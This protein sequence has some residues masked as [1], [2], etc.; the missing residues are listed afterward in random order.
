MTVHVSSHR[1]RVAQLLLDVGAVHVNVER[2]FIF[3]SGWAS[4]V[5][6]DCRRL[7]SFPRERREV[8]ALATEV[9][10]GTV[11]RA[12]VDLVAG[13]ETAGIP[14]AAWIAERLDLPMV[15]VRKQP[16]GFGRLAQIEGVLG[17]GQ[18]VVLVEDLA[19]DG[20]S[21]VAFSRALREAGAVVEHAVVVFYYGIYPEAEATLRAAGLTLHALTD[22]ATTLQ[23][24]EARGDFRPA[25]AAAV[26][27][28]LAAPADWSRAH[29]GV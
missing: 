25:E 11:G 16:K 22:W 28:F 10:E 27:A 2:P 7:V 18:R 1:V 24:A 8:V 15:Y 12:A 4:P 26:R 29:G 14:F 3:T 5:Y 23:V 20:R 21:K 19:T 6:V 17:P 9:L 13:G